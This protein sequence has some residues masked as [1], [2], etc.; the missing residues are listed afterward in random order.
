M[1]SMAAYWDV[2]EI[3][4]NWIHSLANTILNYYAGTTLYTCS[5]QV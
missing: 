4:C 3:F 5:M 1:W 2:R